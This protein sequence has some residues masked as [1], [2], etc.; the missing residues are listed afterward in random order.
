MAEPG[1]IRRFSSKISGRAGEAPEKLPLVLILTPIKDAAAHLP[2]YLH[3]IRT[4]TYP[5]DRLSIGFL[6]SDSRD[7]TYAEL[8]RH[9]SALNREFRR[10][11]IW[12]HDFGYR[13][14]PWPDRGHARLQVQ[15]RTVLAKSR[16]HLLFHALDDE[17]WVLWLDVDVVTY[18]PDLIERLLATGKDIVHPNCVLEPGGPSWDQNA[19]RDDGQFH[20]SDLAHEGDLVELDA[21]GG[22]VLMIKAD[23]HRDGLIFPSFL[24]GLENPRIRTNR[25]DGDTAQ[26][27]ELETEGLGIMARDMGH[28][29]WGMP[30]LEVVHRKG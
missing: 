13:L 17:E 3:G 9:L 2:S 29:P 5:H 27:G 8:K 19:W 22:T 24:Y 16:N 1:L 18:P 20:L 11:Q 28:I 23:I 26:R 25:G 7:H 30:H 21:V 14:P 6:E 10:A 15:R 12:R 4:L